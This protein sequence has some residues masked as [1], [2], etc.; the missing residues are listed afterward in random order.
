MFQKLFLWWKED[1]LLKG[2][3]DKSTEMMDKAAFMFRYATDSF[4]GLSKKERDIYEIDRDINKLQIDIRK[5]IMEHLT[6]NPR[7]DI[8][9]SLILTTIIVDIERLGDYSKN[10][11]EL[12]MLYKCL[13][14]DRYYKDTNLLVEKLRQLFGSLKN[15]LENAQV[16]QAKKIMDEKAWVCHRCDFIIEEIMTEE[17]LGVK[18]AVI[19]GLLFRYLKR[20]G[21]HIGNIASSV[22]N[23]FYRLGY[24]AE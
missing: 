15:S 21:A 17:S 7:Q 18:E 14:G 1:I 9:A 8:T 6:I 11:Y 19:F 23:P 24:K 13:E 10:I 3:L 12:S 4:F 22:A 2:A 16:E 5:K 20:I